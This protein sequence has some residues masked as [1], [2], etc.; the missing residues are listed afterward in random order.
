MAAGLATAT[1]AQPVCTDQYLPVCGL[2]KPTGSKTF[3][4]AC[5]AKLAGAPILH[6]GVCV[7]DGQKRCPHNDL[8]PVCAKAASATR[9]KTYD[10]L[11]WA[12]KDW[13]VLLYPGRCRKDR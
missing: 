4:N 6:P 1:L 8:A 9:P 10:N 13:A 5:R 12:E 3:S 2:V 11:C 7:G